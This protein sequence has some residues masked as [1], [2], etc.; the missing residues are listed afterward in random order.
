M[1]KTKKA[2]KAAQIQPAKKQPREG[3]ELPKL[4]VIFLGGLNQIG[5]NITVYEYENDIVIVDCGVSFPDDNM[6]GIDL[7]IPD[8]T[9]LEKNAD[10][11]R[12][13][14]ITHGH[15]DHIGAIPFLLK[16]INIPI[17]GTA[18]T[19]GILEN[20]LVEHGLDKTAVLN[21]VSLGSTIKLGAF[22]IEF[23]TVNHSIADAAA[24]AITTPVGTTIHSGDFKIDLT[25]P[26]GKA[27]D[28]A[29]L[30]ALGTKGVLA[31]MCESTNIERPGYTPSEKIV[32]SSFDRLF[33]NCDKRVIIATFS[34]NVHRVQQIINASQR[35]GRK[36]AVTGRSMLNVIKAATRLGYI[37]IPDGTLIEPA[38]MKRYKPSQLTLIT[39]GSQGE[40]MSALYRMAFGDHSQISVGASDLVI[41]SSSP[42][43]GN[44]KLIC[45]IINELMKRGCEVVNDDI[46]D[47][48]V[49]GHACREEIK[50]MHALTNPKFFI[51][52]HG[53]YR[54]LKRHADLA[55][56]MGMDDKQI[57]IPEIG[58][59]I[60]ITKR[61]MRVNGSVQAGAVLVD[62]Y[63][64]GDVGMSVLRD[65]KR[66]S[67]DGILIISAA[68]ESVGRY[69][70]GDVD[71]IS[72]GF[73]YAK[74]SEALIEETA[75]SAEKFI[76]DKL[77]HGAIDLAS[78]KSKLCDQ[79]SSLLYQR[80]KRRPIVI[81][82]INEV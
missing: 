78:V 14:V 62:G 45:N 55:R 76:N 23:I 25:P 82:I 70:L 7:V 74:D 9:Y 6:L 32:C 64:V 22:A 57:I 3:K 71:V 72:R 33:F 35:Y 48:H 68:V 53:E 37:K 49:S 54:H 26:E 69:V 19:L 66:M 31:L 4:K 15:E 2:E 43:P 75:K 40:P 16:K 34:T 63:G 1:V 38:E 79:I 21:E 51:P 77:E 65:R 59:V 46:A 80:T 36:V 42:I 24:L 18:L 61:S 20:K 11:I 47:V 10:R 58:K 17:Y 81:A 13:L 27:I 29:R 30:A 5:R 41:L 28:L 67:E 60:E 44:E 73:V 56:E 50:I 8:T 52:M 12:G 39:T